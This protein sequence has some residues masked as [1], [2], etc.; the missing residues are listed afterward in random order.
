MENA[1]TRIKIFSSFTGIGGFEKGII[2]AIG[3]RAEFVGYSEIDPSHKFRR[4]YEN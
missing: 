1:H 2:E 4:H 3:N